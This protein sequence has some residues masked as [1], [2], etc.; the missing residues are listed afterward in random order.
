MPQVIARDYFSSRDYESADALHFH[1]EPYAIANMRLE[2]LGRPPYLSDEDLSI[3]EYVNHITQILSERHSQIKK[4]SL[5]EE[6]HTHIERWEVET[7]HWASM[8]RR[9]AHPSYLRIIGLASSLT[10]HEVER[11][12]LQEL[13]KKPGHWFAALTAITGENPIRPD[14]SFDDAIK[15]WLAWG[16]QQGII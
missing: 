5:E 6:L 1:E 16:R 3:Y 9:L 14:Y 15:A 4:A 13:E 11:A 10:N 12:L 7:K 2:R 8:S